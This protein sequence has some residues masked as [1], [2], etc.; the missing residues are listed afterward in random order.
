MMRDGTTDIGEAVQGLVRL[1]KRGR[2]NGV[3]AR[4][5]CGI[6]QRH[7]SSHGYPVGH[8]SPPTRPVQGDACHQVVATN[9]W[10]IP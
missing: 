5:V 4:S 7:A 8:V 9:I 3:L 6:A 2:G 10:G 1:A